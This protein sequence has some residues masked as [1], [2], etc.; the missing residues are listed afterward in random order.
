MELYLYFTIRFHGVVIRHCGNFNFYCINWVHRTKIL[1]TVTDPNRQTRL[2]QS[3]FSAVYLFL[4]SFPQTLKLGASRHII[5]HVVTSYVLDDRVS[6]PIRNRIISLWLYI[7]ASLLECTRMYG[8]LL[9]LSL[10]AFMMWCFST[11]TDLPFIFYSF[12][13]LYVILVIIN[14]HANLFSDI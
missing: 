9:P 4:F 7:Q 3:C 8:G 14:R 6:I 13:L 2:S 1:T 11:W 12:K 5:T 10:N